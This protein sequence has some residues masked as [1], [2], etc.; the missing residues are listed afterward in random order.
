MVDSETPRIDPVDAPILVAVDGSA[1]SYQAV[2][3]AAVDAELRRCP[4]HLITSSAF[5]TGYGFGAAL[6]ESEVEWL[7]EDARR[8]LTEASRIAHDAVPGDTISVTT[9]LTFDLIIPTMIDRSRTARMI[10]VGNRGR[11]AIGRAV[12][13]SVSTALSRHARCPV[14]VVHGSSQADA[15]SA[16]KP[17]VVGVDGSS[18]SMP[19][20]ELAFE[21]A[22]RRKVALIAVHA[23]SD[24]TG[25][26]LPVHGWEEIRTSEEIQLAESLAGFGERY[27]DVPVERIVVC[28][29]PVRSIL[30]YA[31]GAQLVVLGSH[32]RGGFAGMMLGSTS[33]AVLHAAECPV[34]VVRER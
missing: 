1:I 33:T 8:I 6:G 30:D 2:A 5:P 28:D 25:Y 15:V 10:V 31:D 9:E 18:N 29:R 26:D 22:S 23:W 11:G 27:P 7:R 4:L 24:T 17:I 32:G 34:I 3:W 16:R 19:A 20:V 13:G 12:L 21:E 14:A